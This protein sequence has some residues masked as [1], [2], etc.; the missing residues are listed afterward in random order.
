MTMLQLMVMGFPFRHR[1]IKQRDVRFLNELIT[2]KLSNSVS[3]KLP[4]Y[5]RKLF[6]NLTNNVKK[7]EI[8][9][10]HM[11][12]VNIDLSWMRNQGYTFLDEFGYLLLKDT[13]FTDGND[14]KS[15]NL[16]LFLRLF[17]RSLES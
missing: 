2:D 3:T 16:Q 14:G 17:H 9:M 6:A 1:E 4:V 11:E 5:I 15:V 7:V 8:N 12:K 10:N 13:F